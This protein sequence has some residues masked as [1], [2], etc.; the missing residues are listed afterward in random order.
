MTVRAPPAEHCGRSL[1]LMLLELA[2]VCPY[3][4]PARHTAIVKRCDSALDAVP[5]RPHPRRARTS[6]LREGSEGGGETSGTSVEERGVRGRVEVVVVVA[7]AA[8]G[9]ARSELLR[10]QAVGPRRG[11]R[12]LAADVPAA[13]HA[14][15]DQGAV[16]RTGGLAAGSCRRV[17]GRPGR[18]RSLVLHDAALERCLG[19]GRASHAHQQAIHSGLPSGERHRRP[20]PRWCW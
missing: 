20:R 16:P 8:H 5:A 11:A 19:L 2:M 18:R 13:A 12:P 1:S 10:R 6:P 15:S 14:R 9:R 4:V 7:R 17:I 3:G